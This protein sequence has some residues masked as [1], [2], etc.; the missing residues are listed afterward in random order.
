MRL[1][2]SSR[3]IGATLSATSSGADLPA[4]ITSAQVWISG[5]ETWPVVSGSMVMM[6]SIEVTWSA[7]GSTRVASALVETIT[8]RAPLL[9]RM[10]RGVSIG[11]VVWAGGGGAAPA[12]VARG[13]G[14]PFPR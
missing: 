10:W 1:A 5:C 8:M 6:C 9:A 11:L 4:A 2:V 13:G 12:A 3:Q 14:D 7:A